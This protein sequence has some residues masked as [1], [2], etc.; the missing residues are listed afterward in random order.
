MHDRRVVVDTNALVS[1]LLLPDST[2]ARAV[3]RAVDTCEVLACDDTLDELANVLSRS[4]FDPYVS[5]AERREFLALFTRVAIWVP[6]VHT[7]RACRDSRDDK[8]L[9]LALNG[10]AQAIISG[11]ADLLSLHPFRDIAILTPTDFLAW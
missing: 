7:V 11:D 9:E 3:R 6:I 1:R 5:L 8:F 4:K 2:A 10:E